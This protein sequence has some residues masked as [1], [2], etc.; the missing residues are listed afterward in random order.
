M[1]VYQR[2]SSVFYRFRDKL[3]RR[4]FKV[5]FHW[6]SYISHGFR[7]LLDCNKIGTLFDSL[8][9]YH[10]VL[11]FA[12]Y[13]KSNFDKSFLCSF[14][15]KF[16]AW[17]DLAVMD[18]EIQRLKGNQTRS[19][20]GFVL[21]FDVT[22]LSLKILPKYRILFILK[23]NHISY[24]SIEYHLFNLSCCPLYEDCCGITIVSV[25]ASSAVDRGFEPRSGQTKDHIIGIPVYVAS[26]LSAQHWG[27]R[28]RT[29]WLEIR[30]TCPSGAKYLPAD[31]CLVS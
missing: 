28:A 31:C 15:I 13:F 8:P 5:V 11:C 6:I 18:F 25:L 29:G 21:F 20:M 30:I 23:R 3:D 17:F 9:L 19:I 4:D 2:I 16:P 26:P 24:F 7:V 10:A 14:L 12:F 27:A 22:E 1:V